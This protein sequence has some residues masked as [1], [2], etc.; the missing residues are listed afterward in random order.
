MQRVSG[1]G[2][3]RNAL[4]AGA[5][6][7]TCVYTLNM[8]HTSAVAAAAAPAAAAVGAPAAATGAGAGAAAASVLPVLLHTIEA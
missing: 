5:Q 7:A 3:R 4:H 1:L 2:S 6:A 8:Q